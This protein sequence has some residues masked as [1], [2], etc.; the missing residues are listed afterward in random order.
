MISLNSF[1]MINV[2]YEAY[3]I[4]LNSCIEFLASVRIERP[5]SYR[6]EPYSVAISCDFYY[7]SIRP[8]VHRV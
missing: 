8:H 5:G 1:D 7:I 4:I 6:A 2:L 3:T